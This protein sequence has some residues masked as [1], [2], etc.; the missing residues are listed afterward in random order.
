MNL[1][2]MRERQ[3]RL[4][5]IKLAYFEIASHTE[6]SDVLDFLMAEIREVNEELA[7]ISLTIKA[8]KTLFL[9]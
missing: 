3:E 6:N 9:K 4:E 7:D 2:Q 8:V 1:Q 5:E